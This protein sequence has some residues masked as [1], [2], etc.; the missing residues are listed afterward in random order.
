MA[1]VLIV[2]LALVS[3]KVSL[4]WGILLLLLYSIGHSFLVVISGTSIGF[5]QKINNSEKY[6]LV[7]NIVKVVFGLL[8]I[9]LAFYMFYIGF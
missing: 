6:G 3:T 7:N 4:F 9:A 1:P 8:I 2:L 5:V